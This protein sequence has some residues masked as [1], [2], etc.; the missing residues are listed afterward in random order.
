MI[1]L[2]CEA[3]S[4]FPAYLMVV[5]RDDSTGRRKSEH[6]HNPI[7]NFVDDVG[8]K[9][10]HGPHYAHDGE[11]NAWQRCSSNSPL[12]MVAASPSEASFVQMRC[13]LMNQA[14][15]A[16]K[17]ATTCEFRKSHRRVVDSESD[18]L[19]RRFYRSIANLT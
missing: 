15:R 7:Q 5:D 10:K 12:I 4:I 19:R 6:S 2:T 17:T 3:F 1:H 11:S 16:G 13:R 14:N 9:T 8:Q 18:L